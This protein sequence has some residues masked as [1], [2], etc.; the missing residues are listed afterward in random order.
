MTFQLQKADFWKRFSAWMVDTVLVIVLAMV[1]AL[2][3]SA[4]VQ[5]DAYYA[6]YTAI[7]TEYETEYGVTLSSEEYEKLS[8]DD[9]AAYDE[10]KKQM[11]TALSKNEEA[12]QLASKISSLLVT[13]ACVALLGGTFIAHFI[14]PLCLKNGRTLG[15]KVFGLAVTRT[16]GVKITAPILFVRSMIGLYAMETMAVIMLCTMGIVGIVA[17]LLV[18]ALQIGVMIK[19]KHNGSIHD[20]LSDTAVVDFASQRIFDTQEDMLAYLTQQEED[21]PQE[22]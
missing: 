9:K 5:Y 10:Q 8:E 15:K 17:A 3:T 21:L 7:T 1:F 14:I 22:E 12:M 11:Q 4:I 2:A 20:L 18:Q 13:I 6:K 16:N 19:T